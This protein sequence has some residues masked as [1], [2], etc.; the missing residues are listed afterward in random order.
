MIQLPRHDEII[1]D[2]HFACSFSQIINV[3]SISNIMF[4]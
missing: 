4:S 3:L 1:A 2:H